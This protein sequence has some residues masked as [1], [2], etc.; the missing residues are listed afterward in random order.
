MF[1]FVV[2]VIIA[3]GLVGVAL[4]MFA[5]NI[6]PPIPSEVVM[7]LAGFAA[8]QGHLSFPGVVLAGTA[9][10]LAGAW[11]WYA[12]GRRVRPETLEGWVERHGRWLTI[13]REDLDRSRRLFETRGGLAVFLGR[14]VPGVRT[15][16]SVPAG[17][18]RMPPPAFLVWTA[19]GTA[20][21]TLLLAS[22]GYLLEAE[23][24]RV[25]RW[26]DP[27]TEVL[28]AAAVGLYLYRVYRRRRPK[29]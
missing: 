22:A 27:A 4:L 23:H 7:P 18:V 20:L 9:G 3:A 24:H 11:V 8:A 26:L 12:L 28:L 19:M 14:L 1:E 13:D 10:A 21:W 25:E 5:E 17:V 29:G 15:F 2:G 16:I 6:V